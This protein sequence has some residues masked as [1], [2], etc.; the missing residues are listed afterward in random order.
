M[1]NRP[2][3]LDQKLATELCQLSEPDDNFLICGGKTMS[4]DDFYEG[5]RILLDPIFMCRPSA[6]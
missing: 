1:V 6:N 4:T 5:K 2:A 3:V